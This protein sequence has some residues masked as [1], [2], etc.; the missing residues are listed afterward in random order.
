[1]IPGQTKRPPQGQSVSKIAAK[2]IFLSW[3]NDSVKI[4]TDSLSCIQARAI[5]VATGRGG[6]RRVVGEDDSMDPALTEC[7]KKNTY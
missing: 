3:Q 6:G 7:L 5:P 2:S 1:M 4:L